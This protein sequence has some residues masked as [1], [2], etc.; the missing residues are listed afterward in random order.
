MSWFKAK[1]ESPEFLNLV[2]SLNV[3]ETVGNV[4]NFGGTSH[5][6]A[7]KYQEHDESRRFAQKDFGADL[8]YFPIQVEFDPYSKF[9]DSVRIR[10]KEK[11]LGWISK[12]EAV[13]LVAL[14]HSLPE[15]SSLAGVGKI[16]DYGR[17]KPGE[18]GKVI[19]EVKVFSEQQK[20]KIYRSPLKRKL[21]N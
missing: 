4:Y 12:E 16:W 11:N 19:L 17:S 18:F 20:T 13:P 3:G 5:F 10:Y 9:K 1:S 2:E 21:T 6:K 14:L 8:E 7:S 15:S